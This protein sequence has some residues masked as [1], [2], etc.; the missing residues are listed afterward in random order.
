MCFKLL[1]IDAGQEVGTLQGSCCMKVASQL[2]SG[3]PVG[4]STGIANP[5][6]WL[7]VRAVHLHPRH[8]KTCGCSDKVGEA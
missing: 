1:Y 5:D 6:V 7:K 4:G 2:R 3:A 8:R